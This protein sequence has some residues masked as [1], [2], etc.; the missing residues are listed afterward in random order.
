MRGTSQAGAMSVR[1]VT[2]LLTDEEPFLRLSAAPKEGS[3]AHRLEWLIRPIDPGTLSLH[4]RAY[5]CRDVHGRAETC[6]KRANMTRR[7]PIWSHARDVWHSYCMAT[8]R[9]LTD[10]GVRAST[11][12]TVKRRRTAP[13]V[14]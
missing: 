2:D 8:G 9:T 10:I 6:K 11:S 4:K 3:S 12:L 14:G 7:V 1:V 5:T 13:L